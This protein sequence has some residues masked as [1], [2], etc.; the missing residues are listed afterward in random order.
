MV[1]FTTVTDTSRVADWLTWRHSVVRWE[2]DGNGTRVSWTVHYERELA[3]SWYFGPAQ[4]GAVSLSAG[5]LIDSLAT[6]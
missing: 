3:P 1:T 2:A 5:Y 6:P 4:W